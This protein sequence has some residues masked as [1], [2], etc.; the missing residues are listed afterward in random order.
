MKVSVHE[1]AA[2]ANLAAAEAVGTHLASRTVRNVM[3]AAGNTPLELY[4]LI[5]SRHLPLAHLK[6]FALDEYVGVPLEEPRNC[7][8]LLRRTAVQPWGVPAADYFA[9]SSLEHEALASVQQHE[10]RIEASG[11]LDLVILGLGENAH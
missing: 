7:G 11:G 5:G 6:I 1:T 4:R 3:L 2:E 8:N 9:L 10:R